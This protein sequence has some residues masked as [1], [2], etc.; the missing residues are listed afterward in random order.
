MAPD[1]DIAKLWIELNDAYGR[2]HE[3]SFHERLEADDTF[4]AEY[5][6]R[7]DTVVRAVALQLQDR[8]AALMQRAKEIARMKP[9]EGIKRFIREIPGAIQLQLYF[10]DNL[11]EAWLPYLEDGGASG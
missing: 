4:R 8:Y 2:V 10:Y 1:G 6:R 11:P 9:A 3:R 5:A 7:F